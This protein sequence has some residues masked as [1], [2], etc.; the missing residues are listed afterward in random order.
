MLKIVVRFFVFIEQYAIIVVTEI[1]IIFVHPNSS[2]AC[3]RLERSAA[4]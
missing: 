2:Q 3:A 1:S 4:N